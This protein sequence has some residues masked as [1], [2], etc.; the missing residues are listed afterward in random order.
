[1]TVSVT[2][3]ALG[4]V[5]QPHQI[6]ALSGSGKHADGKYFVD[7]VSHRI[8]AVEHKMTLTLKSNSLGD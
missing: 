7:A 2:A 3:F 1:M 4:A 5:V 6:I 8:D